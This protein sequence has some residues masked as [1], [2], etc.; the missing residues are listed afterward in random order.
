[1]SKPYQLA[2]C[3]HDR[4]TC[5]DILVALNKGGIATEIGWLRIYI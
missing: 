1:M 4:P 2:F 3:E 5:A